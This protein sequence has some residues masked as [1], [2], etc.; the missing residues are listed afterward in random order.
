MRNVSSDHRTGIVGIEAVIIKT[1]VLSI[2]Y[3]ESKHKS[4]F[5]VRTALLQKKRTEVVKKNKGSILRT[6]PAIFEKVVPRGV[7]L[8]I[9]KFEGRH[10]LCL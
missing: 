3:F 4:F 5:Q 10:Q 7:Y 2:E 9:N 6:I 8:P 1:V